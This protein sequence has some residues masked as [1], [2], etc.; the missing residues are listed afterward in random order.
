MPVITSNVEPAR[1]SPARPVA[2]APAALTT[3]QKLEA[4]RKVQAQAEQRVKIGT[5]LL[6]AAE[7]QASQTQSYIE[8]VRAEQN[9]LREK[10]EKEVASAMG[11]YERWIGS[12]DETLSNRMQQVEEKLASI[13]KQWEEAEQRVARLVKRAET[14]FD[15]SRT[16]LESATM[17]MERFVVVRQT[18]ASA[19]AGLKLDPSAIIEAR[20]ADEPSAG[21]PSAEEQPTLLYTHLIKRLYEKNDEVA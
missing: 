13:D 19:M 21:E 15:Q 9:E 12:I 4:L 20:A 14:M 18:P 2:D 3:A 11:Q 6:K 5:Q 1:T 10:L 8:Q 17:K 16:L 7:A